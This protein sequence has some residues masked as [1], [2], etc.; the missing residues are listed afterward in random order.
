MHA[1]LCHE[2]NFFCVSTTSGLLHDV[3]QYVS[4]HP[5]PIEICYGLLRY[6]L[7]FLLGMS[8]RRHLRRPLCLC[9]WTQ[10]GVSFHPLWSLCL[11]FLLRACVPQLYENAK[12]LV[13]CADSLF[14]LDVRRRC[15]VLS[16]LQ[17]PSH[18]FTQKSALSTS[19]MQS[20]FKITNLLCE[21]HAGFCGGY[22]SPSACKKQ[23][24]LVHPLSPCYLVSLSDACLFVS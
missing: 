16:S 21:W 18:F 8:G 24:S 1:F 12:L 9:A 20:Y 11:M 13:C 7:T 10:Q 15:V 6:A 17:V 4:V 23:K 14:G 19:A 3:F 5:I 2:T 22:F